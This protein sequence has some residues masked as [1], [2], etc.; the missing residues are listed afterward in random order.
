LAVELQLRNFSLSK[1]RADTEAMVMA[2]PPSLTIAIGL[3]GHH[4][5]ASDEDS[6]DRERVD[7][8]GDE[9]DLAT[10]AI[11]SIVRNLEH[12]KAAAVRQL[13][14]FTSALE[15]L[16]EAFMQRDYHGVGEAASD[17]RDALNDMLQE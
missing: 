10:E 15:N 4:G 16:C 8:D 7:D 5:E 11:V 1:T 2:K 14:A 9:D 12:G 6:L 17:A 3:P 13:R